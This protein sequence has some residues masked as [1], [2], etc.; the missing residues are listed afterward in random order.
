M[1]SGIAA[2][3]NA[4]VGAVGAVEACGLV[5]H[6]HL[7]HHGQAGAGDVQQGVLFGRVHGHAELARHGRID[8]L[9][10]DVVADAFDIAIAPLL[11]REG[12]SRAAAFFRRPLV[13][14]ARG[15]DLRFRPAGR[16]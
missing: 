4:Q 9:D 15:V 6:A 16:R 2:E 8:E 14:A 10:D 12:G 11:E 1:L 3:R 7:F 5:G 13:G